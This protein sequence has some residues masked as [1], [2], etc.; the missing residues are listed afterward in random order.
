MLFHTSLGE[1][2]F[3]Q[4]R[5]LYNLIQAGEVTLAGYYKGRIY[6]MLSC[7]AGKRMKQQ[8]RVFFSNEEEAL[9]AGFRQCG[10]CLPQKYKTW[11]AAI[12]RP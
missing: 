9:T 3:A 6:G 8:H 11:K 10:H 2:P 4:Q 12:N 7:A 5:R 1:T